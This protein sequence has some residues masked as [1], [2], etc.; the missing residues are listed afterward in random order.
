MT[1]KNSPLKTKP[2]PIFK[3]KAFTSLMTKMQK[4]LDDNMFA[5]AENASVELYVNKFDNDNW[6]WSVTTHSNGAS[7]ASSSPQAVGF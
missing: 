1:S 6:T 4:Y 5:K 3:D 7:V 2:V